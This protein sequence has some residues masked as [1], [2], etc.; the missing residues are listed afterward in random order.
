MRVV[1][2]EAV[3]CRWPPVLRVLAA[4]LSR[5]L[6]CFASQILEQMQDFSQW[7]IFRR[8]TG[9]LITLMIRLLRSGGYWILFQLFVFILERS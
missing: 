3:V 7:V 8:K 1:S 6:F 2:I 4:Y 9:S 5:S